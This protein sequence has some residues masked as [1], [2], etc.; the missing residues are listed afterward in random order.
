MINI[1]AKVQQR[2]LFKLNNTKFNFCYTKIQL[3]EDIIE[4]NR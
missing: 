4:A 3:I 2:F 1:Y